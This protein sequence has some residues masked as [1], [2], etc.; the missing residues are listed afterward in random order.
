MLTLLLFIVVLSVLVLIHELGHFLAARFFGVKV[1]EFGVGFPPRAIGWFKDKGR[2]K[3]VKKQDLETAPATIWSV[4]WMP[5]GGFVRMKGEETSTHDTDSF[6]AKPKLARGII[7]AAGVIMNW[8]L[9]CVIITLG[10]LIGVRGEIDGAPAYATVSARAVEIVSLIPDGAAAKAGVQL[11]DQILALDALPFTTADQAQTIIKQESETHATVSLTLKR[12]GVIKTVALEPQQIASIGHKG[13]GI[14]MSNTG[15][16]RYPWYRAIPQGVALT[17]RYTWLIITGF[18]DLL[19]NLVVGHSLGADVSGPVGIAVMTGKI[20]QEGIWP[21]L[22]FAA[23]LSLNLAVVNFLP[24]PAL[25]GGRFLF[26]LIETVRR[27]KGSARFEQIVHQV[28][29]FF[30]IGLVIL[31]TLRDLHQFGGAILTGLRHM[32]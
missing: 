17:A 15:V 19:R 24:I 11:G 31:V 16:V 13:I 28:G 25:D 20:A 7:L 29:F 14:A 1:E 5:L 9:A 22:Q 8:L 2:W 6:S 10:L 23:L 32:I 27:R 4:N 18:I 21:L 3:R 26:L 12:A 30:L